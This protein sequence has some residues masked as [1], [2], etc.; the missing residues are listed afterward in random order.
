MSSTLPKQ[1][2]IF[3][4]KVKKDSL[5]EHVVDTMYHAA[6]NVSQRMDYER[7]QEQEVSKLQFNWFCVSLHLIQIIFVAVILSPTKVH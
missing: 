5:W 4:W 3:L 1:A 7:E 2:T 6:L